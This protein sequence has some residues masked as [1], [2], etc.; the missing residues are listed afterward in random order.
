MDRG[1]EAAGAVET[2]EL[3]GVDTE[4]ALAVEMQEE[5]VA[6]GVPWR[7]RLNTNNGQLIPTP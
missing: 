6:E 2:A 4:R 7:R 3:I 1:Q 5:T